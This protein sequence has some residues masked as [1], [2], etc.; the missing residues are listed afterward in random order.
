MY[1]HDESECDFLAFFFLYMQIDQEMKNIIG[2]DVK[3]LFISEW[4]KY[5]PAILEYAKKSGKKGLSSLT[6][7]LDI[8][9]TFIH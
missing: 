9:M 5:I 4:R 8:G 2:K 3:P 6:C 1:G 7:D